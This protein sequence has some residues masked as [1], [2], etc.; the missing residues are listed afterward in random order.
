ML[1]KRIVEEFCL[2]EGLDIT[3]N[4]QLSSDKLNLWMSFDGKVWFENVGVKIHMHLRKEIQKKDFDS[5]LKWVNNLGYFPSVMTLNSRFVKFNYDDVIKFLSRPELL[6]RIDFEPKFDPEILEQEVPDVAYHIAPTKN[7][8]RIKKI[9]LAPRSKEKISKHP[10][11]VYLASSIDSVELLADHP[12]FQK[13]ES[14]TVFEVDLRELKK[15][16]KIRWFLDP[17]FDDEGGF[18]TYENIPPK[19][20][21]AVKRI[22]RE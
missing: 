4:P 16:R 7:E 9:G 12:S 10:S 2:Y 1:L 8:E 20:L 17:N 21:K 6:H 5:V 13:N 14:L 18:Y 19:Y 3:H 11:R 22:K 15:V